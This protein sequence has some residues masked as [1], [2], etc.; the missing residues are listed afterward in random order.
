MKK[1]IA[2]MG[3]F[4]LFPLITSPCFAFSVGD[5]LISE[6]MVD[7]AAI[8]DTRGEWFE[9]YNP[10][11]DPINLRGLELGDDGSNRHRF[12]SDLLI[13]PGEFLTLARSAASDSRRVPSA[14]AAAS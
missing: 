4:A 8:T 3:I 14:S 10:G 7:P 6:I 5:L 11:L 9:L 2:R 13:L 12:D 1:G